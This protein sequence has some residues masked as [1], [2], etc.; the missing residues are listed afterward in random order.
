MCSVNAVDLLDPECLGTNPGKGLAR[1]QGRR[2]AQRSSSV[3]VQALFVRHAILQW[4]AITVA[5]EEKP[6][7]VLTG[8]SDVTADATA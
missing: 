1:G 6:G 4:L 3:T 2:T 8:M 7:G 5:E